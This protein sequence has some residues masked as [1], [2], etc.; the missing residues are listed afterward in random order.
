MLS[1]ILRLS[2]FP[3]GL[4]CNPMLVI[5]L[6]AI[7]GNGSSP[8]GVNVAIW[9]KELCIPSPQWGGE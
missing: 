8:E 1:F 4:R 7:R 5:S 6:A 2:T 9:E 3:T